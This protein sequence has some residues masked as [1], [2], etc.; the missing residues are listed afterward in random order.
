[1]QKLLISHTRIVGGP[2]FDHTR[3]L[4]ALY[5][6]MSSPVRLQ[7]QSFFYDAARLQQCFREFYESLFRKLLERKPGAL[8]VAEKTPVNI[9]VAEILLGFFEDALFVHVVRDGRD[10]LASYLEV[11]DRYRAKDASPPERI[12]L[13]RVCQRWNSVIDGGAIITSNPALCGRF[14]TVGFESLVTQPAAE[15]QRLMTFLGSTLEAAQLQ[16]QNL[17]EEQTGAIIDDGYYTRAMYRQPFNPGKVGRWRTSLTRRQRFLANLL[18]AHRLRDAG[19][20]VGRGLL[21]AN[22]LL[23]RARRR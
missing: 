2:E 16:V 8:W 18:M 5:R 20:E 6:S 1:M 7:R 3:D 15:L 21:L 4:F 10:V 12:S 19:Y 23:R 22:R 9:D 14:Y 17:T 13:R 11:R